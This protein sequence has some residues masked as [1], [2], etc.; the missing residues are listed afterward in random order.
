MSEPVI[1]VSYR[2]AT[3]G[4]KR[5]VGERKK[6]KAPSVLRSLKN[7]T[8]ELCK[9][10][11]R[12]RYGFVCYTCDKPLA[13]KDCHTGHF[14]PRSKGGLSLK[15]D[16]KNLRPQCY[17]CNINLGGN[18]AEFYRRLV[19]IEGQE[20]VDELFSRKGLITKESKDY[21]YDL[22]AEYKAILKGLEVINT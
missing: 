13:S 21:H 7:K 2:K 18:G 11:T 8:W 20:Y 19:R 16:L 12:K 5:P 14:I 15:Y 3:R 10:I 4:S 22:I 17:D 6:P 9:Q 1:E